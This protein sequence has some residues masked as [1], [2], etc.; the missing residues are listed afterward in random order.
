M[1]SDIL[2]LKMVPKNKRRLSHEVQWIKV[3]S[4]SPKGVGSLTPLCRLHAKKKPSWSNIPSSCSTGFKPVTLRFKA[5]RYLKLQEA[6]WEIA[7][8]KVG[9]SEKNSHV[10]IDDLPPRA[11]QEPFPW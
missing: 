11:I 6:Q 5:V 7:L 4:V 3:I 1:Y 8:L 2:S 10:G 9:S